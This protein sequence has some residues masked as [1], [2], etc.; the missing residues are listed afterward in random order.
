MEAAQHLGVSRRT[1]YR[2]IHM[3]ELPAFRLGDSPNAPLR[4]D[5]VDLTDWLNQLK[6]RAVV[7]A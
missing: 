4:V 5:P 1:I 7:Q 2:K 6:D 3:D